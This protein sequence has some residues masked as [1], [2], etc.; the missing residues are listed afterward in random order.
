MAKRYYNLEKETK[1]FL[2]R[3][4]ETRGV[5]P[6]LNGIQRLNE[7]IV[8]RKGVGL[9]LSTRNKI[10]PVFNG[11]STQKLRIL[12]NSSLQV[13]PEWEVVIW[14]FP[15]SSNLQEVISKA[16]NTP[17]SFEFSLRYNN[18]FIHAAATG[19]SY[20][21]TAAVSAPLNN[22][23]FV[24]LGRNATTNNIFLSNNN[25][26]P[27]TTNQATQNISNSEFCIGDWQDNGRPANGLVDSV[28]RWDRILTET[29]YTFLYN[30]GRGVS[31]FEVLAYQP[32]LLTGLVSYWQLSESNGI[33][34]DWWGSNHLLPTFTPATT[35]GL[36]EKFF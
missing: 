2:K 6:D 1:D 28:G 11:N 26:I 17:S 7:Y 36:I 20:I 33:R 9:L 27:I 3:M 15:R 16:A 18:G 34:Y 14:C 32:S 13:K 19:V 23:H 8:K 31:F 30:L 29:E 10:S 12:S 24:R 5:S 21:S 4:D 25:N 35:G 22:W